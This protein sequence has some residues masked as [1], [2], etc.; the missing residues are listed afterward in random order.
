M[1]IPPNPST[2]NRAAPPIYQSDA[3]G[4]GVLLSLCAL[5]DI[6]RGNRGGI[7]FSRFMNRGAGFHSRTRSTF[8]NHG[9]S[10]CAT[11]SG[12]LSAFACVVKFAPHGISLSVVALVVPFPA[13]YARL[14]LYGFALSP[15]RGGG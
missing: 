5:S 8:R 10:A 4:D 1:H 12:C 11:H 6:R 3:T 9:L 14:R 13:T 2:G 15:S 7:G